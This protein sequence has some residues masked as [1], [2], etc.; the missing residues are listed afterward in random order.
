MLNDKFQS[1]KVLNFLV[2]KEIY[3]CTCIQIVRDLKYLKILGYFIYIAL[4]IS[5]LKVLQ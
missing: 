4:N 1:N 5:H 2:F 3:T